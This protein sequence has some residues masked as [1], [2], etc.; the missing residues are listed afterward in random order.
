MKVSKKF[1]SIALALV[2]VVTAAGIAIPAL[3]KGP[4]QSIPSIAPPDEAPGNGFPGSGFMSRRMPRLGATGN[5]KSTSLN[6]AGIIQTITITTLAGKDTTFQAD[7]DTQYRYAPG[8]T[9]VSIGNF[10]SI[11]GQRVPDVNPI[12]RMVIVHSEKPVFHV[13]GKV[14]AKGSDT[15]TVKQGDKEYTIK[16]DTATKY[17]VITP[18]A[19]QPVQRFA[20][21]GKQ[22][23]GLIPPGQRS[24]RPGKAEGRP[25]PPGPQAA[26]QVGNGRFHVQLTATGKQLPPQP[27]IRDG[28]FG[29]VQVGVQVRV[30]ATGSPGELVATDV[31]IFIP[32]PKPTP[33]PTATATPGSTNNTK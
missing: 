13:A 5:V 26:P 21:P 6:A 4:Y 12:A 24:F 22:Q 16:V 2:L 7:A 27:V 14:T 19:R 15:F 25:V 23:G 9:R 28:N 17:K 8:I 32:P 10:V 11:M 1:M 29:D 20:K 3:A 18:P 31:V 30:R 33:T